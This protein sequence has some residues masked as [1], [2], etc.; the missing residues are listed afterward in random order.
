M[1]QKFENLEQEYEFATACAEH[2]S[3]KIA[4]NPSDEDL[5]KNTIER[6]GKEILS[7]SEA[8]FACGIDNLKMML[9]SKIHDFSDQSILGENLNI[10]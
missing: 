1:V 7:L 8:G 9:T 6:F 2:A 10:K 3:N 5:F 4:Q